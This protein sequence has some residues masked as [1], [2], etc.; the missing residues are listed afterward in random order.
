MPCSSGPARRRSGSPDE[1]HETRSADGLTALLVEGDLDIA[2]LAGADA[3]VDAALE[4][5]HR[6]RAAR[7]FA[8]SV[9]V[10]SGVPPGAAIQS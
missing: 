4:L 1:P 6:R 2:G 5:L 9:G 7:T 10:S 8:A 3:A